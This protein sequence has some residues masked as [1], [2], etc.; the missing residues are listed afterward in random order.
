VNVRATFLQLLPERIPNGMGDGMM[1][2]VPLVPR[3]KGLPWKQF[4]QAHLEVTW[5][6]DFFIEEVWTSVGLVT[7]YVLFF[8]H[9]GSR[10]LWIA[11]C[12]PQ[13][14]GTR[15]IQQARNFS[16]VVEDWILPCRYLFHDR[17][18]S[19]LA[20][21]GTLKSNDSRILKTS[22]HSPICNAYAERQVREIRE[23]LDNLILSG[24]SHLRRAL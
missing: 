18:A 5:A 4:I 15:M 20:L 7:F 12:T 21:D 14:Y 17:D 3:R 23:T 22:P 9:L 1:S 11:G 16:M 6:T 19:F 24:E 2:S 13:P 8:L 10:R